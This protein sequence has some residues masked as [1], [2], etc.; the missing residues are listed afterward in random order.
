MKTNI[1]VL[2]LG[3]LMLFSCGAENSVRKAEQSLALG[4]YFNAAQM[5]KKAYSQTPP[6]ERKLRGERAF[7]LAECYRKI[8]Y[9]SRARG[10]YQN[11]V[12]YKYRDSIAFFYLAEMQRRDKD[13]KN[14]VKNYEIY[15]NHK[16]TD[17][18]ALNGLISAQNA[19]K[20]KEESSGYKVKKIDMFNSRRSDFSP[21]LLG[22]DQL[23]LSSTRPQAK[24]DNLNGITGVKNGDFFVC[25]KDE[26]GKWTQPEV[27]TDAINS[28]EDEGAC[29]FTP[30]GKTMYFTRCREDES[31]P[32]YAEIFR[33]TRSDASW[34]TP[35]ACVL[36]KDSLS[37]Y[38]HPA[39]S[40]DG[41]WL[42]FVSD[43][44]GGEGGLDIWRVRIM[45]GDKFGGVENL[46]TP[47][48][49][50]GDEMFPTFRPNGDLYFSSNG[51]PGMGGLD[52]WCAKQDSLKAWT[53]NRLG[54]PLNSEGDD[55][56]LTFDGI[57]NRGFFSSNRNDGHGWDHI[58]SFELAENILTVQG[59]VYEKDGYELPQALVYM[60][61][62]DGT[63]QKIS[64]KGDGSFVV[65]VKP[66]VDYVLLGTCK[67][68]LNHKQD[69]RADTA[70]VTKEYVLQFPLPSISR[71]VLIDNVLYEFDK[72]DL[73]KDS[74]T[75]LMALVTL[76]NEN[77]N[78]TIELGAHCDYRGDEKYN[79][80]LSQKRAESCVNF[81][82]KN[83]IA[84]ERLTPVG[85]GVTKPK[86]VSKKMLESFDFLKEGDV[87]S[88]EYIEKLPNEQQE[89]CNSL[90][91]RTE[92]RVLRT[93]YNMFEK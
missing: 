72:A 12:R 51:H 40:P 84:K 25:K 18:L 37:S 24:G 93:T 65:E 83:G 34:S 82:I 13:Y 58:Y 23:F 86:T 38:A 46:G 32:R 10:A 45:D 49:T 22:D 41:Q 5:Y 87:L 62:N 19:R 26:K 66:N 68:F 42:Y 85:Y 71:P 60:V 78:I 20:W 17:K 1:I 39:V 33:S 8:N 73:T 70:G 27:I 48:N 21:M 6:K 59:W 35:T 30:D 7:A 44:P 69:F 11:A 75:E 15:L 2:V 89:I 53:L 52:V 76:L 67:G 9:T 3:A 57:Y 50:P 43:M 16:P 77:P 92:F 63:N 36:T 54:Y 47:I 29:C 56:G 88:K 31:Y 28:E 14:A 79:L 81:L 90:N 4:E 80:W 55:F 61:G 91:R 64:V 74:E